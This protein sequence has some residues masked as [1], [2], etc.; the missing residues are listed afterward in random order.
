MGVNV[1]AWVPNT[2]DLE[3]IRALPDELNRVCPGPEVWIGDPDDSRRT[4]MWTW[5]GGPSEESIGE[6]HCTLDGAGLLIHIYPHVMIIHSLLRW[7]EFLA[8]AD[9]R[10][11]V[12][13]ATARVARTLGASDVIWLPDWVKGDQSYGSKNQLCPEVQCEPP[14]SAG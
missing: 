9:L 13:T 10:N 6:G 7:R 4:E 8:D 12:R 3:S 1:E 14:T 2:L 11:R 5:D